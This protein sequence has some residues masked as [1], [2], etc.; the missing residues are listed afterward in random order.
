MPSDANAI[1]YTRTFSNIS[2]AGGDTTWRRGSKTALSRLII[3]RRGGRTLTPGYDEYCCNIRGA[4][5]AAEMSRSERRWATERRNTDDSE[6]ARCNDMPLECRR[7][8]ARYV[9]PPVTN[10]LLPSVFSKSV[11]AHITSRHP[12]NCMPSFVSKTQSSLIPVET[13]ATSIREAFSFIVVMALV[14][15]TQWA[16]GKGKDIFTCNFLSLYIFIDVITLTYNR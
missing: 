8:N 7:L 11:F 13:A 4:V 10:G 1:I 14:L 3:R 15:W 16:G 2:T 12:S 5:S 6:L 9:Q